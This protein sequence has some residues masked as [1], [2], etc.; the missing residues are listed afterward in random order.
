VNVA[1]EFAFPNK[2][3]TEFAGIVGTMVPDPVTAVAERFHVTLSA[4]VSAHV[5]PVAVPLWT[6]SPTVKLDEPTAPE[7]TTVKLIGIEFIG[8]ACDADWLIVTE[9]AAGE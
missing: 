1:F 8:S 6:I 4:L 5:I 3:V 7:N 2:S 9:Y